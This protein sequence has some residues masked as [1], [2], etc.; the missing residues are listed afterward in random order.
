LHWE[1]R[2][3]TA[4]ESRQLRKCS[5]HLV[6]RELGDGAVAAL[7]VRAQPGGTRMVPQ[8]SQRHQQVDQLRRRQQR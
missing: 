5:A 4:K 3:K 7:L 2:L 8:V 1:D 6:C